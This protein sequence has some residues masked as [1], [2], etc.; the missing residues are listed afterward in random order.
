MKNYLLDTNIL[1]YFANAMPQ[2]ELDKIENI[3]NN[4]F[5]IS[6]ISQIEFLGW[7]KHTPAGFKQA[8]EFIDSQKNFNFF[9][10]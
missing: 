8:E 3:L 9:G 5:N 7:D 1:N 4:S 2:K 10:S 6:I